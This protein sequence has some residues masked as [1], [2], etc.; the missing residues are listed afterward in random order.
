LVCDINMPDGARYAY[1]QSD[2]LGEGVYLEF[3]QA[4][5]MMKTMFR[6]GIAASKAWDAQANPGTKS[7]EIDMKNWKTLSTS[8]GAAS[9]GW[10]RS[11]VGLKS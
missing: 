11:R 1:M 5:V 8:L 9:V 7:L 3:L 6:R 4:T 2:A 10:I